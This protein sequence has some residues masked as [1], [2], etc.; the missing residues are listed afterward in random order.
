MAIAVNP[1]G[2]DAVV[3]IADELVKHYTEQGWTLAGAVEAEPQRKYLSQQNKA[4]LLDT[5]RE[6]GIDAEDSLTRKELV[7]LIESVKSDE[8]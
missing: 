3:E 5:A 2:S 4:E 8:K 6:F 7:A 1:P